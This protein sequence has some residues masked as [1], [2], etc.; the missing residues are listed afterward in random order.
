MQVTSVLK[1]YDAALLEA[2]LKGNGVSAMFNAGPKTGGNWVAGKCFN[3]Y[4]RNATVSA[5][6]TSGESFLQVEFTLRGYVTT[7][8][9]DI[10]VNFI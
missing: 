10:Y 5:F 2:L 9:K 3:A 6:T 4:L 1:Q 8:S 7:A